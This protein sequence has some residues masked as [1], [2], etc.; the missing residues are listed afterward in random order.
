MADNRRV[1]LD[2]NILIAA[3]DSQATT[4]QGQ[5]DKA[6]EQFAALL[7]DPAVTLA[8]TPLIRYKLFV[9]CQKM[10]SSG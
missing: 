5:V 8:I 9:A 4:E 7:N 1:L 10:V 2:A 6:L 3:L